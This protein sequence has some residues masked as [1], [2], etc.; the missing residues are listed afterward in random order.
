MATCGLCWPCTSLYPSEQWLSTSNYQPE[1]VFSRE[2]APWKARRQE[3][4]D[5]QTLRPL[6]LEPKNSVWKD[7]TA[8]VM[9]L[10]PNLSLR[11]SFN[12]THVGPCPSARQSCV[13]RARS[14]SPTSSSY[15]QWQVRLSCTQSLFV[16]LEGAERE[17]GGEGRSGG[18]RKGAGEMVKA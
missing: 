15:V 6:V 4:Q 7:S 12:L 8:W 14:V 18:R 10:L 2:A 1:L 13:L 5:P 17:C 16:K 9:G 11:H 3:V